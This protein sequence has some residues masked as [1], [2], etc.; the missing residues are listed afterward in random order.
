MRSDAAAIGRHLLL[1]GIVSLA[2]G[3]GLFFWVGA[4]GPWRLLAFTLE[5]DA[6]WSLLSSIAK[7]PGMQ[8]WVL[9]PAR[10]IEA[11]R[12]RGVLPPGAHHISTPAALLPQTVTFIHGM[13][14]S[15]QRLIVLVPARALTDAAAPVPSPVLPPCLVRS[16][17]F[18]AAQCRLG[19]FFDVMASAVAL[20]PP[21]PPDRV[22]ASFRPLRFQPI[23]W[24]ETAIPLEIRHL[25]APAAL[26]LTNPVLAAE[27]QQR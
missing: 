7:A 5:Q 19:L 26:T 6:Q 18:A 22:P 25:P 3:T 20:G 8:P 15:P 2:L 16:E 12:A 1:V 11:A 27:I 10:E 17:G 21:P 4:L 14:L 9:G 23:Q 13:G 24:P